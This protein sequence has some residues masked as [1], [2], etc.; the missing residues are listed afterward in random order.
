MAE[1]G[2][3]VGE[4]ETIQRPAGTQLR[5]GGCREEVVLLKPRV[6]V[7]RLGLDPE[8]AGPGATHSSC[9]GAI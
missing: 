2:G 6:Q 7:A 4:G 5:A 1:L 9:R 8:G 3:Q